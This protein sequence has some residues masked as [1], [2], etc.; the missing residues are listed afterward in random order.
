MRSYAVGVKR[1]RVDVNRGVQKMPKEGD[2]EFLH[3]DWN[4]F[5]Q[6]NS[7]PRGISGKV[8]MSQGQFVCVLNDEASSLLSDSDGHRLAQ[9]VHKSR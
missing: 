1:L 8:C 2:N 5:L 7:F 4:P 3:L 6:N 9:F